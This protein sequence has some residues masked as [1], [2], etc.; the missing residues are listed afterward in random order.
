MSKKV[1]K[2]PGEDKSMFNMLP[3]EHNK[4]LNYVLESNKKLEK[5][6]EDYNKIIK[7]IETLI[8]AKEAIIKDGNISSFNLYMRDNNNHIINYNL[9]DTRHNDE[10]KFAM[11]H[12]VDILIGERNKKLA[13][14]SVEIHDILKNYKVEE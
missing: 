5:L 7:Q 8:E 13:G 1:F 11:L 3:A 10:V 12:V 6:A 2:V 14:L 4:L 9:E